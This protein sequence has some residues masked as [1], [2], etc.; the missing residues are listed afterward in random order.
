MAPTG[1][2]SQQP[3]TETSSSGALPGSKLPTGKAPLGKA[4]GL[5]QKA[6][7][8]PAFIRIDGDK[9]RTVRNATQPAV[10]T[11]SAQGKALLQP[12]VAHAAALR[13]ASST[14]SP[15]AA[16]AGPAAGPIA[17]PAALPA[18]SKAVT[19][20]VPAA[21]LTSGSA[22]NWPTILQQGGQ[23]GYMPGIAPEG[24]DTVYAAVGTSTA[25]ALASSSSDS[26]AHTSLPL[27][28]KATD[29]RAGALAAMSR[30]QSD[31][32]A[33]T[34]APEVPRGT[35][36]NVVKKKTCP[37]CLLHQLHLFWK[38]QRCH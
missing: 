23:T 9:S 19:A 33:V 3:S 16:A 31:D 12:A 30:S 28:S 21:D 18:T 26:R 7:N 20:A 25:S 11:V 29:Q 8:Q 24:I 17:A 37:S 14:A 10:A 1:Q 22:A 36:D 2:A 5:G 27:L 35:Q 38:L 4:F 15:A 6:A 34:A 13:E 32:V